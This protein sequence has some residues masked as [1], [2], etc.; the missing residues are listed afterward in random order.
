MREFTVTQA[1]DL[2]ELG[3]DGPGAPWPSPPTGPLRTGTR[4]S[5]TRWWQSRSWTGW[6]TAPI[7]STCRAQLPAQPPS[8]RR[9][10][11][12]STVSQIVAVLGDLRLLTQ[13][14]PD[15][16]ARREEIPATKAAL[17]ERIRVEDQAQGTPASIAPATCA[18]ED[19]E[20]VVVRK[21]EGARRATAHH[22]VGL[23]HGEPGD[24]RCASKSTIPTPPRRAPRR[25][26]LDRRPPARR[27]RRRHR[28]RPGLPSAHALA[29]QLEDLLD[30]LFPPGGAID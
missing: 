13:R 15:G 11:L 22:R 14:D 6:S 24:H 28:R 5:P 7:T 2:Y 26:R 30:S 21:P 10:K 17:G 8:R 1:D 29:R 18:R 16:L 9:G 3:A 20:E 4:C 27:S 25:A 19:C 23:A 12:M